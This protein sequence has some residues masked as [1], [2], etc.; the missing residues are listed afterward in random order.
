MK[1][2]HLYC[3]KAPAFLLTYALGSGDPAFL[4]AG[5]VSAVVALVLLLVG[6]P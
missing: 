3:I 6:E 5:A 2:T 4:F 1:F